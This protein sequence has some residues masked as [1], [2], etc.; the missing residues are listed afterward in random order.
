LKPNQA[1]SLV[2]D[3]VAV[4]I[5]LGLAITASASSSAPDALGVG[6]ESKP[7]VI[8]HLDAISSEVFF[9][10]LDA[11]L[12]PNI[13]AIFSDGVVI[14]YALSPFA[15]GTEM[16]YPRMKR[17]TPVN[18]DDPV[19]WK[20]INRYTG[21]WRTW[22]QNCLA[23]WKWFP[24]Y[25]LTEATIG[26]IFEPVSA[27]S[28]ANIPRMLRDFGIVEFFWFATD[29][30]GHIK[31][32]EAQKASVARF[33]AVLRPV[34]N[35]VRRS[36]DDVNVV[37]YCD[38][39]M[40]MIEEYVETEAAMAEVAG[41]R[42]VLCFYPNMY[43]ADPMCAPE[44]GREL[45]ARHEVDFVFWREGD[46]L[47]VG[48]H[49]QGTVLFDYDDE[50]VSYTY[51]GDDPF[52]YYDL[53]Y[54]GER[55]TD[56]EWLKLTCRS[57]WP[58]VPVQVVRYMQAEESGDVVVITNPP[59]GM[60]SMEGYVALH[61]GFAASDCT[62]PVLMT[63]PDIALNPVPEGIWLHKLNSEVL[64]IDP[65]AAQRSAREPH[66]LTVSPFEAGL[67]ISPAR[68]LLLHAGLGGDNSVFLCETDLFRSF[69]SRVW[70]GA[71]IV[72]HGGGPTATT[73]PALS[74]R[75]EVFID[76][77]VV[78]WRAL[79]SE[80]KTDQRLSATYET[81]SGFTVRWSFPNQIG[82]GLTW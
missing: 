43:L 27:L 41:E 82:L 71:G 81:Q 2:T 52:G 76:R 8:F 78:D 51:L 63:G 74:A 11:G 45:A 3:A 62:V 14:P 55:L 30:V 15:P 69:N 46:A 73:R 39:G 28:I 40:S 1:F 32:I 13:A 48:G 21:G 79:R 19:G 7:Y 34:L 4:C 57:L 66:R 49:D 12:L 6:G 72:S 25:T 18:S 58:A 23:L 16:V 56:A 31:G 67:T 24:R 10:M 33:D 60:P 70:I 65:L 53:G 68:S 54:R 22:F 36:P 44:V 61:K 47:I 37:L 75:L 35:R 17:G 64:R 80:G 29:A 38:H 26:A 77:L 59:K 5:I 20:T 42:A 9:E 50:H